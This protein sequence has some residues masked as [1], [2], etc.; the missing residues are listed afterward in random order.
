MEALR[1]GKPI[2]SVIMPAYNAQQYIEE[3]IGSVQG[4]TFS[5]WELIVVDDCSGDNTAQIVSQLAREDPRIY[6][7]RNDENL[8]AAKSRNQGLELYKGAYVAFLDSDDLWHPKKLEYQIEHMGKTGADLGYTAYTVMDAQGRKVFQDYLV[9]SQVDFD[10]LLKENV[11]GCSTVM[12]RGEVGKKY[13]FSEEYYHED[14]VLWLEMLRDGCTAAGLGEVLVEY[15]FHE[16]S[17]AGN[18]AKAAAMRWQIYREYLGLSLPKSL[19][20]FS[21]YALSGLRKYRKTK[22]PG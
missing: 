22:T 2:V 9:P 7:H 8:G 4:Q 11:I 5:Q 10:G 17:K 18:K 16:Q 12:L 21:H 14:Y 1:T 15:R 13:R 19:W 3:A 6:L 20:Y